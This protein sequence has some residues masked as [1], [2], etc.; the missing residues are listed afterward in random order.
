MKYRDGEGGRDGV[1]PGCTVR[2]SG[3]GKRT[4]S[5]GVACEDE[6]RGYARSINLP[7]LRLPPCRRARDDDDNEGRE[8][9]PKER[10]DA[11][12]RDALPKSG[13][14]C[15]IDE[16]GQREMRVRPRVHSIPPN[17]IDPSLWPS[18]R[19]ASARAI[20][21][22]STS[23]CKYHGLWNYVGDFILG[24]QWSRDVVVCRRDS[25]AE[26][27]IYVFWGI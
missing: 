18:L 2:V 8:A 3:Q 27:Y 7:S 24:T 22:D 9:P 25:R 15:G 26:K 20:L 14:R 17:H 19:E 16:E 4:P 6:R 11:E 1:H 10:V 12:G 13:F 5:V 23:R 21:A